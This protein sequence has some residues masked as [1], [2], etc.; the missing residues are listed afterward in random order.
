M[1]RCTRCTRLALGFPFGF[2][3]RQHLLKCEA[4]RLCPFKLLLRAL[5]LELSMRDAILVHRNEFLK[6]MHFACELR[7][8]CTKWLQSSELLA[9]PGH[10]GFRRSD[11]RLHFVHICLCLR[12]T[13][14]ITLHFV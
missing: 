1:R 2:A 12:C 9:E 6:L 3:F 14:H 11:S 5:M 8:L 4:L 13:F 7:T 10:L